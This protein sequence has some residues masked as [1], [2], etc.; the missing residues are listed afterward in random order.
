MNK[1]REYKCTASIDG[2]CRNVFGN[3]TKCNGFSK[4]CSLRPKYEQ[5]YNLGI[6]LDRRIKNCFGIKGDV[7]E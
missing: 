4:E 2:V 6:S 1:M 7:N 3:G 5:L